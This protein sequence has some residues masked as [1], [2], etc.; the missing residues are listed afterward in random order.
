MATYDCD[1]SWVKDATALIKRDFLLLMRYESSYSHKG[2]LQ[3]E[4]S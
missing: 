3:G 2:I 4:D 1:V